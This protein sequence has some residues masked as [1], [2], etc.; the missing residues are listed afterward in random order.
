MA[1]GPV[2]VRLECGATPSRPF[3]FWEV[4]GLGLIG[5][6]KSDWDK[7]GGMNEKEFAKWGGEDWE[8]CDRILENTMEVERLKMIHFFHYFHT[9]KG[10][11][12]NARRPSTDEKCWY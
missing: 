10:M 6:Y 12:G 1:Y 3:G 4:G 11:W 8:L 9:N 2:L 5:M 7:V